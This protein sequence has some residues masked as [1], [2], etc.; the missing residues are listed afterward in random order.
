MSHVTQTIT[1]TSD[2]HYGRRLPP[3]A[4]GNA[5]RAIPEVVRG[6]VSMAFRGRSSV[7]GPR[8]RWLKTATDI[9]FLDHQ[10]DDASVLY[11]EAPKLGDAAPDLY[12]HQ[13]FWSTRPEPGDTGF[14]LLGDVLRD[15]AA[16]KE[17]SD[18]FDM[19]LLGHLVGF[20]NVLNGTFRELRLDLTGHES[21]PPAVINSE[22]ILTAQEF[23]ASTPLPQRV[24]VVGT[25]DMVRSSTQSFALRLDGGQEVQGDLVQGDINTLTALVG[26]PVLVLGRA[27]YRASGNVLRIEADEVQPATDRD[28]FFA[29]LPKPRR[30]RF[31]VGQI[32][33]EQSHKKGVEAILG[34]WPG[35]ETDEEIEQG[36][37]DLS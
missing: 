5:L 17:N 11:F 15:V 31:D 3:H 26:Q 24:R 21:K 8:P 23:Q 16:H 2:H 37:E 25:L 35:D 14:D 6:A 20:K 34:K 12:S 9:R 27:V 22:V 7:P 30:R 28:R 1:L 18:R 4:L 19:R 13:A 32:V 10:G 29:T 36:L 33:R